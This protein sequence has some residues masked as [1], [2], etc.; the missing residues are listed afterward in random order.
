MN[1]CEKIAIELYQLGLRIQ[2]LARLISHYRDPDMMVDKITLEGL[3]LNLS[4]IALR[5][6]LLSNQLDKD[7]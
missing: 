2:S 7:I 3:G 6:E 4:E 1:N 5:I